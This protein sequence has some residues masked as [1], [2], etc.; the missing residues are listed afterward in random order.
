MTDIPQAF[1]DMLAGWNETDLAKIRS[2]LDKALSP[3][4]VFADPDNYV[5]GIDA[6]A[7]MVRD[8]R[9]RLPD[10]TCERTSGMNV[11]HDRY[12]YE[13]LVSA[14]GKPMVP[15]MDVVQLDANGKV[16]RVDGFFG[17]VPA[18]GS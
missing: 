4:V 7:E 9:T 11:H 10:A 3:S 12:R 8:F 5:E 18:L 1:E 6:F 14:G 17:P 13:W 16:C 2:H 15:G